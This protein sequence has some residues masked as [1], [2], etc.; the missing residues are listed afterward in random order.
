MVGV[1]LV[2]VKEFLGHR[3]IQ[4]TLRYS[5][6]SPGHLQEAVSK[7]GLAQI[8]N[9]TVT[10]T[11]TSPNEENGKAAGLD[12]EVIDSGEKEGWV[13]DVDSNHGNQI[14]EEERGQ[15]YLCHR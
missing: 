10:A 4:T 15:L 13:G 11:V 1:H 7:G 14:Q 8:R 9:K 5:H 2:A 12:A 3:D 6:L